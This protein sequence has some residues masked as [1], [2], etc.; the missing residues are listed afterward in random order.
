MEY[1]LNFSFHLLG[2]HLRMPNK[3]SL[4]GCRGVRGVDDEEEEAAAGRRSFRYP[5]QHGQSWKDAE[6]LEVVE[7]ENRQR[8]L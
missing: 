8:L 3:A 7:M 1:S 5:R 2:F 4:E 6:L